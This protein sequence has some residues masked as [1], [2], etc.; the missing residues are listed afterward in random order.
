MSSAP[1]SLSR[2]VLIVDDDR[3]SADALAMLL[4]LKGHQTRCAYSGQDALGIV[5]SWVPD[6]VLIDLAMPGMSG[7]ELCHELGDFRGRTGARL[8]ACTG[9]ASE[10][11]LRADPSSLFDGYLLKPVDLQ[12]LERMFYDG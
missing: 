4:K 11:N 6:A 5:A 3:G 10:H 1:A 9:H 12:A 2:K 7:E 8:I